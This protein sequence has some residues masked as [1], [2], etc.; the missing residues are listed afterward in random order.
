VSLAPPT[1]GLEPAPQPLSSSL[2]PQTPELEITNQP[3]SSSNVPATAANLSARLI[4][5]AG[6]VGYSPLA[7]G[8]CGTAVAVPAAILTAALPLWAF[9]LLTVAVSVVGSWAATVADQHWRTHDNGRI[10]IDEVAGYFVTI[11]FIDRS[12]TA[13]LLIGFVLFRAFDIVKP[14]PVGWIDRNVS[15]GK[16]VILDDIAAGVLAAVALLAIAQTGWPEDLQG[17]LP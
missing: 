12:L 1:P 4:A 5:T 7:P 11:A 8:T 10:V 17:F 6:G 9:A 15:G 13:L 16:G 3:P 14:P 2:A